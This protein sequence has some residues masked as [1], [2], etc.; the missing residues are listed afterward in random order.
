MLHPTPLLQDTRTSG[1]EAVLSALGSLRFTLII[2]LWLLLAVVWI[3]FQPENTSLL[4][5][6]PF[7]MLAINLIAAIAVQPHFRAQPALLVFHL[8][9]LAIV[10]LALLGRMTY[11]KGHMELSDGAAFTGELLGYEAGPWHPWHIDQVTFI[12]SGFTVDYNP[13]PSRTYTKNHVRWREEGVELTTV[14]GDQQ[15]LVMQGYRFYTS[16]NKGF[17]PVF[18][19]LP[20]GDEKSMVTGDLHMPSYP[21]QKHRQTAEWAPP[22]GLG[23]LW[24]MLNI[25]EEIIPADRSS[26]FRLP[27]DHT[28]IVRRGNSRYELSPGEQIEL[29]DGVLHYRGLRSWMGYN[30]YYDWTLPWLAAASIVAVAA[31]GWHFWKK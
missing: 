13:G 22:N 3:L 16:F 27:A 28:L 10:V 5:S 21:A 11:L 14:I 25:D 30:V 15:P 8:A 12:N 17:A 26:S 18:S 20:N 9:L 6:P 19:W 1:T 7:V 24:F 2:L 4:I 29:E 31:M 23:A